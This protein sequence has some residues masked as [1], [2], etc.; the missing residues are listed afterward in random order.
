[1]KI[2]R[3]HFKGLRSIFNKIRARIS[4][5]I[6]LELI[7]LTAFCFI[8]SL[9]IGFILGSFFDEHNYSKGQRVDYSN[10]KKQIEQSA[11]DIVQRFENNNI[12]SLDTSEINEYISDSFHNKTSIYITDTQGKVLYSNQNNPQKDIDLFTAYQDMTDY[13]KKY[14]NNNEPREYKYMYPL[15]FSDKNAYLIV[16]GIPDVEIIYDRNG[17]DTDFEILICCVASF[18]IIFLGVIKK[19]MQ[20]I[21][22]ISNG[23]IEISK[24]DLKYKV[25]IKGDDELSKL[26][27]NIN[28]MASETESRIESERNAEKTKNELI[29]NVSHDL[30]TPLTSIMGYIGLLRLGKYENE[31]Q[32][33]E[34]L[35]IAYNKSERLKILIEDLFEYTKLSNDGIRLYKNNIVLNEFL[36]Q[37]IEELVPA[38]EENSITLERHIPNEKIYAFV[39]ADKMQRVFENLIVN[40]VK[41]SYKP[42]NVKIVLLKDE[43]NVKIIVENKGDNIP[44]EELPRLFDRFYRTDKARPSHTGSSGL[45]LAIAKSI[46]ELHGGRIFAE[47]TD[48]TISFTVCLVSSTD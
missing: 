33:Q 45:G 2:K 47:C 36:D 43:N 35:D 6:R 32:Q 25:D 24:G 42:S 22:H 46:V 40:A 38:A 29:T 9:I 5:S 41:Y 34:Y 26:A 17:S 12:S 4:K 44:K 10:G 16:S 8:A 11:Q 15:K 18:I 14:I 39:D 48:N 19:K 28:Y 27:E 7:T 30:R 20:Y 37:V 1:M 13:N 3:P 23:L 31:A 21:E